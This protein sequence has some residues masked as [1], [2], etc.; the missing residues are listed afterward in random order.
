M[1]ELEN[2]STSVAEP[3]PAE[4]TMDPA[5]LEEMVKAGVLYG[6]KKSKTHPRMRPFIFAT[7]NNMEIIDLPK[8]FEL[9]E[10]AGEFL[11]EVAAKG[12]LFMV[13]GTQPA[14]QSLVEEFAKKLSLAFVTKRWL[15]G[16]LTNFKTL[17]KRTEYYTK[18]KS[19]LEGGRLEK[20]TKKERT[21]FAKEVERM[22]QFFRGME[23][24]NRLPD[25]VI[26]VNANEHHTAVREAK[27]MKIPVVAIVSTDT[28]PELVSYPVPANDN[29]QTSIAWILEKFSAK[30]GEGLKTVP[31]AAEIKK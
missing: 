7:R 30:I 1:S 9:L 6:R 27:K 5:V 25:A 21:M 11:K 10:K 16:T 29:A 12:G 31:V 15:G 8:T 23:I 2:N 22:D 20:Y 3:A 26:V 24:L 18:L 17:R 19:D 4:P 14:A 13:V 28:D